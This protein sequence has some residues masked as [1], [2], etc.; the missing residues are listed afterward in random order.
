MN[1]E[2]S[3]KEREHMT[4]VMAGD[5]GYGYLKRLTDA[6]LYREYCLYIGCA[7]TPGMCKDFFTMLC[8]ATIE[9]MKLIDKITP[10]SERLDGWWVEMIRLGR[11]MHKLQEKY[12]GE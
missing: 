8:E 4:N 9:K 11:E 7:V 10:P 6:E 5:K 2:I 3:P 12:K 1:K